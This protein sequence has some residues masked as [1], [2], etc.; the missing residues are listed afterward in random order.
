[1]LT[2]VAG[3]FQLG[4]MG[5]ARTDARVEAIGRVTELGMNDS[6]STFQTTRSYIREVSAGADERTYTVD[7]EQ[8]TSGNVDVYERILEANQSS[9]LRAYAPGNDLAGIHGA[10]EMSATTGLVQASVVE[11][12]IPVMPIV[13]RLFFDQDTVD[14]EVE[15]WSVQTGGLY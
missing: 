1:M 5:I 4:R 2:V 6:D 14:V 13:R 7:D 11:S 3:I 9:V 8:L 15:V 12:R 10:N